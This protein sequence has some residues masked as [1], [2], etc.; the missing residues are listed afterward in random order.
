MTARPTIYLAGPA[1]FHPAAKALCQYL[2]DV[3]AEHGLT[4]LSPLD[5][6]GDGPTPDM[7]PT[8]K[9]AAIRAANIAKIRRADAVIACISPFRG[10]GADAGTAWEM[11]FAE[12]LGKPVLAWCEDARPYLERVEHQTDD[13]GRAFCT[14]H[15]MEV[16]NFGLLD[17]LMLT[18]TTPTVFADFD[19]AITAA[20]RMLGADA[21]GKK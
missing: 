20:A 3:C 19:A 8:A 13:D 21:E 9:A 5:D 7:D 12:A 1:V 10:P 6:D 11:G 2:K 16:E 14:L 17:N 18:A 15:G 4:G